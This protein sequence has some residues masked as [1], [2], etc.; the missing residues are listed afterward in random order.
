MRFGLLSPSLEGIEFGR[1]HA[2]SPD[3]YALQTKAAGDGREELILKARHRS[4][5]RHDATLSTCLRR[6]RLHRAKSVVYSAE[7]LPMIRDHPEM[8]MRL[9]LVSVLDD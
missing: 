6:K 2:P 8:K 3:R 1:R 5:E 9:R 4:R 7:S